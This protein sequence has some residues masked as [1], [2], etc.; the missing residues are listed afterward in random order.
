ML[1]YL[2]SSTRQ[3]FAVFSTESQANKTLHKSCHKWQYVRSSV[4]NVNFA[5]KR[6]R[7]AQEG[8]ELEVREELKGGVEG[9]KGKERGKRG[10]K[11]GG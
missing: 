9:G 7:F 10:G 3:S 1:A 6:D 2:L 5:V 4:I 8:M 11:N